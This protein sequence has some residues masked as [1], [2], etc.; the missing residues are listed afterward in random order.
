VGLAR[1]TGRGRRRL[2]GGH[3]WVFADDVADVDAEPGAVVAVEGPHGERLGWGLH[4]SQ[5]KIRVRVFTRQDEEPDERFWIERVR[6][7]AAAREELGLF[8]PRGACRLLAGDADGVPGMVI[9]HYAGVFV[10]QS[11][12]QGS[13]RLRDVLVRALEG[14][15]REVRAVVDRSDASVRRLEGLERRVEVLRGEV[16]A[17]LEIREEG[18][19]APSLVYEVDVLHGHKTGHYLDQR[20]N[21]AHAAGLARGG[22]ALD[23]FCYDGLFGV[24]AALAG[25]RSVLCIDQSEA[26]LERARRNAERNGVSERVATEKADVMR[27]LRDRADLERR[28]RLVIV[29]PPAFAKNRSELEGAERGYREL[30]LRALRL[31]ESGGRLVTASCSYAMRAEPFVAVLARAAS[32]SGRD[33]WLEELR[34]ASPDHPVLLVLPESAYLKCAFLRV[35]D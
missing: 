19:E 17:E 29:D 34:G 10:L 25:A 18:P 2:E 32:L 4:S 6:R 14:L 21:R 23:A 15:G 30:N 5:S 33:V 27:D 24:R 26:A 12:T 31:V 1:L 16:P 7:A 11:G 8:D 28:F 20:A 3:P 13:D 22:D 35:S 9:D